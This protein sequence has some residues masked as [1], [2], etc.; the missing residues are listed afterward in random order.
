VSQE[1]P[2]LRNRRRIYVPIADPPPYSVPYTLAN[3]ES[4]SGGSWAALDPTTGNFDWQ[5]AAPG[6]AAALG[7]AS[8][9]NGVVFVGDMAASQENMFALEAATGRRLW[10][11]AAEGSVNASPAI[12]EGVLYWGS[13]YHNG[14]SHKLYAFSLGGQ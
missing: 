5:V 6:E 3:G 4:D 1:T 14:S 11:F 7:P 8:K 13:G 9:A 10:S 2:Q 12:V